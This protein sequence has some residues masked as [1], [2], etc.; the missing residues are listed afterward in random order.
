MVMG[1]GK[2][3]GSNLQVNDL[4]ITHGM[5]ETLYRPYS[6]TDLESDKRVPPLM[7]HVSSP[8]IGM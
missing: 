2:P 7:L 4:K 5:L 6:F 8:Y 3:G 1:K